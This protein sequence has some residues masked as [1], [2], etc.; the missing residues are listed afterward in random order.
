MSDLKKFNSQITATKTQAYLQSV[1]GEKKSSFVNNLTA[2]VANNKM[3]QECEPVTIMYAA[4]KATALDLPLDQNLGFAYVLPYKNNKAGIS[5]AQFQ[6]GFKG[7]VQL[8]VRSNEFERINVTDVRQG[9]LKSRNRLTGDI[10][11]KWVEDD[12]ERNRLPV[13]G[14]VGYFRLKSGYEKY[15]YWSVE[16][17]ERHGKTYSQT[18][19][20]GYGVWKDNFDAM[21]KKGLAVDTKIPTPDGFK[22][23]GD[24]EVGDVVYNAYGKETKVIAKSEVKHLPC[25]KITYQNGDSIVCDNEHL[26]FVANAHIHKSKRNGWRVICSHDL[27]NIRSLGFPLVVPRTSPVEMREKDLIVRPYHLGYWLG[28]GSKRCADL[29]C[30]VKDASEIMKQFEDE[31][32][33]N[34]IQ[35]KRNNCVTIH[36]SSATGKRS[37]LSSFK[38]RL[39]S[40][41]V[42]E[43]KHI[44][45]DYKRS[46]IEQRLDLIRGLCD[47]D[48]CIDS[49]RG[50]VIY[51]SI[52]ES[53]ANGVYEILC[54]LGEHPTLRSRLAKG[55]GK[56]VMYYEVEW[57]PINNPFL[58]SRKSERVKPVKFIVDDSI[59]SIEPVESVPT[60]C[61]AVDFGD[62]TDNED[63]AFSYLVGD[64][65]HVTHNTVL[66]LML[67]KGD[68]PMSVEMQQAI[69]YD[70]SVILDEQGTAKYIDNQAATAE[71]EAAAFVSEAEWDDV[72]QSPVESVEEP[73]QGELGI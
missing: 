54:S 21:A 58:L 7:V 3:L 2:L 34:S 67:N 47:S 24:L 1:L 23:I 41:G 59:K 14:Y 36:V 12:A 72:P 71:D 64:G 5:E 18:F 49:K 66:K 19:K 44:P 57:K 56:E 70:Q 39:N 46:S 69:K 53:L 20:K 62:A 27:Y 32:T 48:A 22:T 43:N 10:D 8:C 9:E 13:I 15:S 45:V 42:L 60:Q 28:N 16:E 37:D 6:I 4:L 73:K 68:A 61:I 17:L 40:I 31:Y 29:S 35:D 38:M 52:I 26:W 33:V 30:D 11:F 25:Y 65:F 63:F 50:R 51:G 55:F